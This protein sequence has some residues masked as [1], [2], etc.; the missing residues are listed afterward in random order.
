MHPVALCR[1]DQSVRRDVDGTCCLL[2]ALAAPKAS[3]RRQQ[4]VLS[5]LAFLTAGSEANADCVV[6]SGGMAALVPLLGKRCEKTVI[7]AVG[8]IANI[9]LSPAGQ[10]ECSY[11]VLQFPDAM[12]PSIICMARA[13][14]QQGVQ[15]ADRTLLSL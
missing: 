14:V 5:S 8:V 12:T 11:D 1:A 6:A 4:D 2:D 10:V 9:L 3:S 7:G 15:K 13:E